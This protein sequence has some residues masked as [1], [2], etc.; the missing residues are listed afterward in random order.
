MTSKTWAVL[1]ICTAFMASAVSVAAA[2][3]MSGNCVQDQQEQGDSN[4]GV[5]PNPDCP[6]PDCPNTDAIATAT[7]S[8]CDSC[9]D[10]N[11]SFLYG[12]TDL[13]APH[14]S[15]I[16]QVEE[17]L[18]VALTTDGVCEPALYSYFHQFLFGETDL[19]PPHQAHAGD[20]QV[21]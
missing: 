12:E 8:V 13:E 16:G 21:V 4:G 20:L 2:G 7:D 9:N 18:L 11:W 19:E 5:C 6:N 15:A 3:S 10:Y 1:A 17:Y 14:Q